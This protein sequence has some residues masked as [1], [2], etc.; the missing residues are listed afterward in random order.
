MNIYTFFEH[1]EL[2]SDE[3]IRFLEVSGTIWED[4]Q[5]EIFHNIKEIP[6]R[7][8]SVT[9]FKVISIDIEKEP[10]RGYDVFFQY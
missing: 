2:Y 1:V 10:L 6:Q 4:P 5:V 3:V 7:L 9:N 8:L